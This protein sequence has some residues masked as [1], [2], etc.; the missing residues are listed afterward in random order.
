VVSAEDELAGTEALR[1]LGHRI[2]A[3]VEA[4]APM[5]ATVTIG[6]RYPTLDLVHVSYAE[7]L[8]AQWLKTSLGGNAVIHIDDARPV[9]PLVKPYPVALERTLIHQIRLGQVEMCKDLL[10][11]LVDY[12]L[13][14]QYDPPEMIH[15]RFMELIALLSRAVI[16]TGAS[17][18]RVLQISH[19]RVMALNG[20]H[21]GAELKDWTL[22]TLEALQ[23][24]VSL[25]EPSDRVVERALQ[26][27]DENFGRPD[28]QLKEVAAAAHVS[29]SHLAHLLRIHVGA[30]YVKYMTL[31]RM[32]EGKRLLAETDLK[33]A[34]I[35]GRAGYDD[36]AYFYRVFR[37]EVGVTPA[38]YRRRAR[39]SGD[40]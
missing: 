27:M 16:E 40:P 22:E 7:A 20:L 39:A 29:P 21:S 30:S 32:E 9:S 1:A 35:A 6:R 18:S 13:E 23:H 5:T 14:I 34:A 38:Q 17:S 8:R 33:V 11:R 24:E 2:R 12:L 10:S 4:G 28:L 26:F 36:P 31:L 19:E 15:T 3:A 25:K 37:R